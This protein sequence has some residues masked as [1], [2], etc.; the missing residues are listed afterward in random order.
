MFDIRP[1]KPRE[2]HLCVPFGQAFHE[3]LNLPGKFVPEVFVDNWMTFLANYPSVILSLWKDGE[4]AGGLGGLIAPDLYDARPYAQ[5]FFWF[6]GKAYRGGT[7]A[8]RLLNAFEAWARERLVSEIRM[9][10]MVSSQ[11]DQL[12]RLYTRLGYVKVEVCYRKQLDRI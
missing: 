7:G 1:L 2:I 8:I 3:E 4:L 5:E 6:I 12:E 10:H 11:E 9:V